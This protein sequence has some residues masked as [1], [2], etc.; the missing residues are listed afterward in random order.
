M[1]LDIHPISISPYKMTSAKLKE[2][3]ENSKERIDKGF[4]L[5]K[6]LTLWHSGPIC[7]EEGWFPYDVYRLQ[8]VE[9]G[10]HEK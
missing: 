6:N 9:Q 3:K 1:T 2:L 5:T 4:Y 10:Y 7:E 8:L